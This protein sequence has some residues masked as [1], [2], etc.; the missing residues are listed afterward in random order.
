[1]TQGDLFTFRH[2]LLLESAPHQESSW[3]KLCLSRVQ[4]LQA[5]LQ[6]NCVAIE[7]FHDFVIFS[8]SNLGER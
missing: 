8:F 3:G 4:E 1:M 5:V 2:V 7:S 6:L